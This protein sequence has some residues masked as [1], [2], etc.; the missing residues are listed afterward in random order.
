[1][2]QTLAAALLFAAAG[3]H[4][5]GM[6]TGEAPKIEASVEFLGNAGHTITDH[7]GTTYVVGWSSLFEPKIYIEKYRGVYP[8]YFVGQTMRFKV[9]LANRSANG[10]KPFNVRVEAENK[11][12]ETDGTLGQEI[13]P[14]QSWTVKD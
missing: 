10:A 2:R 4:A 6:H 13:G 5:A 9:R 7:R 11:V 3:A 14:M 1:M 8:L 12:L